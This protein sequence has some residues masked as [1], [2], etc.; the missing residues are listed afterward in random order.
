[1]K[2][3]RAVLYASL[4]VAAA[5]GLHDLARIPAAS[6]P[7]LGALGRLATVMGRGLLLYGAGAFLLLAAASVLHGV[8]H[9]AR[10][11]GSDPG[12]GRGAFL[13][14]VGF[15]AVV[16]IMMVAAL[17]E[18]A[19]GPRAWGSGWLVDL[20]ASGLAALLAGW[21][22]GRMVAA[23]GS[24]RRPRW[25][26]A[27]L[28]IIPL[29]PPLVLSAPVLADALAHGADGRGTAAPP[30]P[31]DV[32]LI[33]VDSLR[34]DALSS[35]G[36]KGL[37][38]PI[39]DRLASRGA[40]FVDVTAASSRSVASAASIL[41]SRPPESHGASRTGGPIGEGVT[42]LAEAFRARG[43]GTAGI[44]AS[45]LATRTFGFDRGF[46][47]WRE[48]FDL[49]PAAVD[50]FLLSSRLLRGYGRDQAPPAPG[51]ATIIE[52]AAKLLAAPRSAPLFLYL[53]LVDPR[54][55]YDP[56]PELARAAD[57]GYAGSL[58]FGHGTLGAILRGEI[59]LGEADVRHARALYGAEVAALDREIGRL[60]ESVAGSLDAG[61][62]LLAVT[63]T[64]GEE[65]MEHGSFGHGHSLYQE[66]V[67][68]PF[69]VARP[70]TIPPGV[71]PG[72]PVSLLDVAPTLLDAAG[73]PA[74]RSFE[75]RSLMPVIQDPGGSGAGGETVFSSMEISDAHT[76]SRWFRSARKGRFEIIASDADVFGAGAWRR[77][78]Y[79]LSADPGER[80]PLSGGGAEVEAL[81]A[82]LK[83]DVESR[84]PLPPGSSILD[85]VTAKRL[86]ALGYAH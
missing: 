16:L 37:P 77:E 27:A 1:V 56:P 83:R 4:W 17:P 22:A 13:A 61:R 54:D 79:D 75:G 25:A 3:L 68:V 74:E 65:F 9:R 41:T 50:P 59:A 53:H 52:E 69:L 23:C 6:L 19:D 36:G 66:V 7:A 51:A 15:G 60:L 32:I 8:V 44:T 46:E 55:P 33:V 81:A 84:P 76:E 21:G 42:T 14:G 24:L 62:T 85:P 29:L 63:G 78:A 73:A 2:P 43:Y 31:P 80:A 86:R 39:L 40:R 11:G 26:L 67:R 45:P 28:A 58:S 64:H 48:A 57:P 70:G 20:L 35:Y 34:A 38:T 71:A 47:I 5:L 18:R 82:I 72:A 12:G 30:D 49:R 10:S